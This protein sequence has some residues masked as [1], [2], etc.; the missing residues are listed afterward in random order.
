MTASHERSS[1]RYYQI[2]LVLQL[3]WLGYTFNYE[4]FSAERWV[5]LVV[6]VAWHNALLLDLRGSQ[7]LNGHR[8][9]IAGLAGGMGFTLLV[10]ESSPDSLGTL[11]SGTLSLVGFTVLV[12]TVVRPKLSRTSSP[13]SSVIP[14][15]VVLADGSKLGSAT[16]ILKPVFLAFLFVHLVA[17]PVGLRGLIRPD[18]RVELT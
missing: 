9:W 1:K 4:P 17:Y 10:Y 7:N 15:L 5:P 18:E 16:R 13:L 8:C 3:I 6:L 14:S 12:W 2:L 11:I